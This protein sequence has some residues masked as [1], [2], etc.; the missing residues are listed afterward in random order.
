VCHHRPDRA[1]AG[2]RRAGVERASEGA[3]SRLGARRYA[4]EAE[5]QKAREGGKEEMDVRRIACARMCVR[6]KRMSAR[7]NECAASA[8]N[9]AFVVAAEEALVKGRIAHC[10][11]L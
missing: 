3:S 2:G 4:K 9:N 1:V 5:E 7:A 10:S 8:A 11:L 6:A